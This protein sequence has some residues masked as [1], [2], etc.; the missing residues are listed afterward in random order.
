[1]ISVVEED[2][3]EE[4][5]EE[6]EEDVDEEEEEEE[7][8]EEEEEEEREEEEEWEEDAEEDGGKKESSGLGINFCS[9]TTSSCPLVGGLTSSSPSPSMKTFVM[10]S[11]LRYDEGSFSSLNWD[12]RRP[13][14]RLTIKGLSSS[15][16]AEWSESGNESSS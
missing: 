1:L 7:E 13:S 11:T 4:E 6:E 14:S 2:E 15:S 12:M 5:E 8:R 10:R 9:P 16:K 3:E